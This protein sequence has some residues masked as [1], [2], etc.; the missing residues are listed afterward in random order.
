MSLWTD[1]TKK[2]KKRNNDEKKVGK[3][4]V[5]ADKRVS[6]AENTNALNGKAIGFLLQCEVE[7]LERC[8]D[9]ENRHRQQ[10]LGLYQIPEGSKDKKKITP[11][12]K[13][14]CRRH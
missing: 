11:L 13:G 8:E 10:N 5:D 4:S 12:L 7:L 6:T 14:Y 2:E 3:K 9:F 1:R